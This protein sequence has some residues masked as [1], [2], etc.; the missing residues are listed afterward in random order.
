MQNTTDWSRK[1]YSDEARERIEERRKL[2]T[3]ELQE[4]VTKDWNRL[5]ADIE[6]S[7]NE[8]PSSAKAHELASRWKTLLSGFTGGDPEIQK[9]LNAMYADK[10]NWP[11]EQKERVDIK[12][13]IWAFIQKA[14]A[15]S[16]K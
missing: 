6:A 15:A 13:E 5:F 7:I 4:Q 11:Q 3:P 2:W 1:Y 16:K 10:A 12:P 8:D 9:G 14:F